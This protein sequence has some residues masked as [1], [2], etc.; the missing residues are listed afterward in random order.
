MNAKTIVPSGATRAAAVTAAAVAALALAAGPAAAQS[1]D[2]PS[3]A[4]GEE[5]I[6]GRIA[7]VDDKY[8]LQI[9]DD[10]GYIDNVT[11][12]DG[13]IINPTGLRLA[14]GQSV[15]VLGHNG[16]KSFL[17]NEIDTPYAKTGFA[18][19]YPAY[20]YPVYAVPAY[21]YYPYG[22][23]VYPSFSLG[24]RTGGFGFRGVF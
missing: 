7:S 6:S 15:T 20:A 3:Y 16:G 22:Y 12:R 24:I 8:H 1:G 9:R 19:A 4:T 5:R 23:R 10:R 2:L 14:A 21:G 11:L 13:T 17:A 18:Y